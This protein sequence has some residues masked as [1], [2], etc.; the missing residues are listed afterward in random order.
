MADVKRKRKY[1][2]AEAFQLVTADDSDD[3]SF[4]ENDLGRDSC[5]GISDHEDVTDAVL[6]PNI[7]E[8]AP[9]ANDDRRQ[10][11]QSTQPGCGCLWELYDGEGD[12]VEPNENVPVSAMAASADNLQATN[13]SDTDEYDVSAHRPQVDSDSWEEVRYDYTPPQDFVYTGNTGIS[14]DSGLTPTSSPMDIVSKF[15]TPDI[16]E[17]MTSETNRY[18][19]QFISSNVIKKHSK[20]QRWTATDTTELKKFLGLVFL[21]GLVKK[22]LIEDYWSTDP[23]FATPAVNNVMPRDRFELLLKFWHFCDNSQAVDGD[24]LYKLKFICDKL[25]AAFQD[26][27]Y[28]S[29][30]LSIDEAM[31]LWRGRLVFR[32]YIPGKKHKYGVKLY[33]LCEPSGYVWNAMIYCGK[34]DVI[35]GLGH[36]EAVV[37]KLMNKLFDKGH[38]LYVD[39]FYTGVPLARELLKRKTH[40]CGTLRRNR[41]HLPPAVLSAKLQKGSCVSRRNRQIVVVKWR[42]NREVMM[43]STFHAGRLLRSGKKTVVG[44]TSTNLMQ[45]L[46]TT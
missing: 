33:L 12:D 37:M 3:D 24:R 40:V 11:G 32:Q 46:T 45:F 27:Y 25:L 44:T 21:M 6:R 13:D 34:S 9:V 15:I 30:Q 36:S 41:K 1:T 4:E 35:S 26:V 2:F 17:L 29:K 38:E 22:P 5:Y 8:I 20:S 43:L 19:D 31:V 23:I 14:S 10:Q 28:P 39:N 42:D 7:D 16:L 18:A